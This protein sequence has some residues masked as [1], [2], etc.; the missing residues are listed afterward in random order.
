MN[1]YK[2]K[3]MDDRHR[4][5]QAWLA[6]RGISKSDLARKIGVHP[7]MI[8]RIIRGER[9]PARRLKQL[10]EEGERPAELLPPPSGPPGR[11]PLS[12]KK[13]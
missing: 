11:P 3:T 4:H 10:V 6:F 13:E 2:V 1:L 5:L 8:S 9:A 7:S 12:R